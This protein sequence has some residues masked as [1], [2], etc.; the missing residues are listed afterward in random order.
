MVLTVH[1]NIKQDLCD[2][3]KIYYINCYRITIEKL[4]LFKPIS[5]KIHSNSCNS[6][7]F[8]IQSN[9]SSWCI[10]RLEATSS[11]FYR[12][13]YFF[14]IFMILV[15]FCKTFPYCKFVI[16]VTFPIIPGKK[17]GKK[18]PPRCR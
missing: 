12:L 17:L 1:P 3:I 4:T 18:S 11:W 8:Y 6:E 14:I 5:I 16:K 13:F 2:G 10:F 9:L 15:Y 7:F